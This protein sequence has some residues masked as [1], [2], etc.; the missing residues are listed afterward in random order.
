[1]SRHRIFEAG[2]ENQLAFKLNLTSSLMRTLSLLGISLLIRVAAANQC[3]FHDAE[4]CLAGRGVLI[5]G[6]SV[7][8]H[9]H[10]ALQEVLSRDYGKAK[11]SD[12]FVETLAAKTKDT[13]FSGYRESEKAVCGGGVKSWKEI[14]FFNAMCSNLNAATKTLLMFQWASPFQGLK[15][16][17]GAIDHLFRAMSKYGLRPKKSAV[18][19]NAGLELAVNHHG[20]FP[21]EETVHRHMPGIINVTDKVL[22]AGGDV[23]WRLSTQLCCQDKENGN[24]PFHPTS[25]EIQKSCTNKGITNMAEAENVLKVVNDKVVQAIDSDAKQRKMKILDAWSMTPDEK[26][27]HYE[28]WVHHPLLAYEQ[29]EAWMTGVLGCQCGGE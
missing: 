29:I 9:W 4:M 22:L 20:E 6:T 11:A 8:R 26:C 21:P 14:K 19:L 13:W 28:D 3:T 27:D 5:I 23:C 17:E 18:V 1:M 10:F 12:F 7:S 16:T 15:L 2:R 24:Q 25:A